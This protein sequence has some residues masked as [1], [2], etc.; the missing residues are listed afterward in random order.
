MS[1]SFT[2]RFSQIAFQKVFDNLFFD[3]L[4]FLLIVWVKLC[5]VKTFYQYFN[6]KKLSSMVHSRVR[7]FFFLLEFDIESHFHC[8][9]GPIEEVVDPISRIRVFNIVRAVAKPS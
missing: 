3:L 8:G 2:L 1:Y 5:D 9:E 7:F 4:L 6:A